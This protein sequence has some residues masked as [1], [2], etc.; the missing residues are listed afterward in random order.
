M[1]RLDHERFNRDGSYRRGK[2]GYY[3]GT[4]HRYVNVEYINVWDNSPIDEELMSSHPH[5]FNGMEVFLK[6]LKWVIVRIQYT[7]N[8]GYKVFLG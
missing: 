8:E 1:T 2:R 6:D 3:S 7:P 4:T 5:F